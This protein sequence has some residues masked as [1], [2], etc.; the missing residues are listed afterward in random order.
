MKELLV[1]FLLLMWMGSLPLQ[2]SENHFR[3]QDNTATTT[4]DDEEENIPFEVMTIRGA[5]PLSL[6]QPTA[7]ATLYHKVVTVDLS[8]LPEGATVTVSRVTTGEEVYSQ[9]GVGS[10]VIDLSACTQGQYQI[11]VVSGGLWLQ[12]KFIL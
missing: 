12:G 2:A 4:T 8:E 1:A 5:N 9:A 10:M 11:D 3:Q 7:Y 6:F